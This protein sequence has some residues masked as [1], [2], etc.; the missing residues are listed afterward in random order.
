MQSYWFVTQD[1][2]VLEY[3]S[4]GIWVHPR[5]KSSHLNLPINPRDWVAIYE[6]NQDRLKTRSDGA[7]AIV[8]LAQIT[9]LLDP[10]KQEE[11]SFWKI[12]NAKIVY[13]NE[14]AVPSK[15]AIQILTED[16]TIKGSSIGWYL[17]RMYS[18]RITNIGPDKFNR[19]ARL[20]S[21]EAFDENSYQEEI[22]RVNPIPNAPETP[23][24]PQYSQHQGH[25]ELNKDASLAKYCLIK[26]N[27]HCEIN[28]HHE[29]F[30][31][32]VTKHNYV[33][34]HHLVPLKSQLDFKKALDNRANIISLC[35]NCHRLLHHATFQEKKPLLEKLFN[36]EKEDDL[37]KLGTP[38]TLEGLYKLY[39]V[40]N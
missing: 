36:K 28:S 25:K 15:T 3:D 4:P 26:A 17:N 39:L 21:T 22:E 2:K 13:K 5:F 31:S 9:T 23:Q 18:G 29:S 24:D 32:Q 40:P 33:E 12:A 11:D 16:D 38:I 6:P 20:F 27:Y 19:I 34:A 30:I 14:K 10:W 35:P 8:A 1:P 7:K 37:T